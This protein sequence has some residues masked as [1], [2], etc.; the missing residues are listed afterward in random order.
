[1]PFQEIAA[2][3]AA[4]GT[5]AAQRSNAQQRLIIKNGNMV[6]MVEDTETA[7]SEATD[8]TLQ[9]D[10]YI[11]SQ[12]VWDDERGY[13]Y[14]T[15]RV[16]I[17]VLRFEGAMQAFRELGQVTNEAASGEDVTDQFVDL[18]SRL[19][20]LIATRDRLRTFLEQATNIE[21]A[22]RINEELK[23]VEEEIA[24]IQGRLNYLADRASF[25]TLDL[26]LNPWV[27]TPTPSP[28]PTNTPIPTAQ[29]WSP[30]NTAKLASVELQES[31]QETADFG[32][33]YGIFC[34]PWLILLGLVLLGSWKVILWKRK[35]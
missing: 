7:V 5:A 34:G 25:S 16:G 30:G 28:T 22:L 11:I 6:I 35:S 13:R 21:E 32:I 14:A 27:P 23:V 2:T 4:I 17:P 18:Q 20:N 31:A 24:V 12:Q 26:T 9:L 8:L 1:M 3:P 33:Y 29:A 10:G 15:M 19:D